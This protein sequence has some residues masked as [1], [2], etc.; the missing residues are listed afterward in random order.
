MIFYFLGVLG[1]VSVG[2]VA[3]NCFC[4][5]YLEFRGEEVIVR[6]S[7]I[8]FFGGGVDVGDFE[9]GDSEGRVW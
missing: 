9:I 2:Y 4:F 3:V 7:D 1:I 8:W 6:Y 5:G